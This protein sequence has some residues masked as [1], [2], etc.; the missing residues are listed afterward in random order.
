MI[1]AYLQGIDA[2][3]SAS[4]LV[5]DVEIVRRAIEYEYLGR[6]GRVDV[7]AR[8]ERRHQTLVGGEVREE[9][10]LDL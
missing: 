4:P 5:R 6:G 9:P 8:A 7:L 2:L 3:L 10:Q 1:E